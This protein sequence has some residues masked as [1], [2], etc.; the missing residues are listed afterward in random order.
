MPWIII[1]HL[2]ALVPPGRLNK[3]V[4]FRG[5]SDGGVRDQANWSSSG[6]AACAWLVEGGFAFGSNSVVRWWPL[7]V[8]SILSD[9]R[10]SSFESE[11]ARAEGLAHGLVFLCPRPGF[12]GPSNGWFSSLLY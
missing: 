10:I 11:L 7:M 6:A 12:D 4:A 2:H 9:P 5:F 1:L 3:F 8:R